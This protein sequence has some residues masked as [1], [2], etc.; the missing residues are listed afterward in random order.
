MTTASL[1]RK[2][3]DTL[4]TPSLLLIVTAGGVAYGVASS[5]VHSAHD[6]NLLQLAQIAA[7]SLQ[8][9]DD[10]LIVPPIP[11]PAAPDIESP[12]M[13]TKLF[14]RID[15]AAGRAMAGNLGLA[16][17]EQPPATDPYSAL[18]HHSPPPANPL[19]PLAREF[20][21]TTYNGL[22]VR[23]VRLY[24]TLGER[25]YFVTVAE[26]L[27]KRRDAMGHLMAGFFCAALL[28]A[29]AAGIAVRFGIPS[30]LA[31][32]RTLADTLAARSGSDLSLIDLNQVP[33]EV[34]DVV[35]ALNNLFERLN[36]ASLAQRHFLQDAAH[37]LRTPLASLQVELEMLQQAHTNEESAHSA[38][39]IARVRESVRRLNR[40]THQLLSM[41]RAESGQHVLMHASSLDLATLIDDQLDDWL[42][43]ADAKHLDLGIERESAPVFGDPLL[44]RELIAN[45]I[46]NALKYT[47]DGG[48]ITLRCV[49]H[50]DR[51][52]LSVC[53]SGPGIPKDARESVFE[54][55][56]RLPDAPASGSGL[57]L[58]IAREIA[59]AH[60]GSIHISDNPDGR[61]ACFTVCLPR[62]QPSQNA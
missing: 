13:Q 29:A 12:D 39:S 54:R 52:E 18:H 1:R 16:R 8:H 19:R 15:N 9:V 28:A 3:A 59:H 32:L 5:V 51:I 17:P 42:N 24:H 4:G 26:T 23:A 11:H 10:Q 41:A 27:E 53:D 33:L 50:D 31:P 49:T 34:R 44:L 40:L 48:E 47:P 21:N 37:Q 36:H 2:L 38:A 30:G 62:Y 57:G 7:H 61:G 43:R 25:S 58:P 6:H 14:F 35:A 56:F 46:D 20:F 22:P 60:Q 55:F 45:L